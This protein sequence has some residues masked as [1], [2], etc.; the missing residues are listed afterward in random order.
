MIASH[1]LHYNTPI[2]SNPVF[3]NYS[4]DLRALFL[5]LSKFRASCSSCT[6]FYLTAS[7]QHFQTPDGEYSH[8]AAMPQEGTNASYACRIVNETAVGRSSPQHWRV[9]MALEAA[10]LYPD[11]VVIPMHVVSHWW[12]GAHVGPIILPDGRVIYDCTH[13]CYSPFLYEPLFL[14]ISLA[15]RMEVEG[16]VAG[17][18]SPGF[19]GWMGALFG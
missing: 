7:R 4:Q 16:R 17:K 3:S 13:I 18:R 19:M 6:A 9:S 2:Q 12:W 14:A 8:H 5:T 10:S 1:G 15:A 11:V